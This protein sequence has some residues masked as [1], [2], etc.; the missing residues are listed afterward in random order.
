MN[1]E[2]LY[3][4]SDLHDDNKNDSLTLA[5]RID[6]PEIHDVIF[7]G[8]VNDYI[9]MEERMPSYFEYERVNP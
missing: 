1:Y 3:T 6:R 4:E 7:V 2:I 5:S 9:G 8:S